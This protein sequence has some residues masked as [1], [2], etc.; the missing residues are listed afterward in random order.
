MF[1]CLCVCDGY[2]SPC[3]GLFLFPSVFP[4][5]FITFF[6]FSLFLTISREVALLLF[7]PLLIKS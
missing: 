4:S 7:L 2:T 1:V 5:G 6:I 3:G